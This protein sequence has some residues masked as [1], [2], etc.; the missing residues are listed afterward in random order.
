MHRYNRYASICAATVRKSLKESARLQAEKRGELELRYAKWENGVSFPRQCAGRS[1]AADR[2]FGRQASRDHTRTW[3]TWWRS[4]RGTIPSTALQK[5]CA[6][7]VRYVIV[8]TTPDRRPALPQ[9]PSA[10]KVDGSYMAL[11]STELLFRL[12]EKDPSRSWYYRHHEAS[13]PAI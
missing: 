8:Y 3:P 10:F 5:R 13:S 4:R 11:S 2:R 12:S 1:L 6:T 9:G 7:L